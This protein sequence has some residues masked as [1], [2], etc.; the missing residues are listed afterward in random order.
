MGENPTFESKG[1]FIAEL[2]GEATDTIWAFI[3][4]AKR[5]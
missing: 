1:M 5:I 3:D 4:K 2:K